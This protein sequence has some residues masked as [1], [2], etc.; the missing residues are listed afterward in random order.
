[1][2][3]KEYLIKKLLKS[4]AKTAEGLAKAKRKAAKKYRTFCPANY[5]LLKAYH[6]L[7]KNKRI[8][9]K[10]AIENLL[11]SRPV[12]S[13]SGIVNISL[14][15]KPYPCPGKCIYCPSQKGAPKSYLKNEP[16]VMRAILNKYSPLKQVRMRLKALKEEGH[17]TDKIEMRIIGGTWSYYPE[18]YQ[19]WF[20]KKC[21]Q[22]CN[23][24]SGEKSFEKTLKENETAKH[25]IVGL[26]VETRPDFITQK[27]IKRMR[28]LGITAVELGV[29]SL[30]DDVLETNKR[31]HGVEKTVLAT[32]LLKDAGF[33]VCYQMMPNLPGSTLK[34]D[35]EMFQ[36]L[37]SDQRFRPDWLKIY[38]TA[39][40]KGSALHKLW[41]EKKYKPYSDRQMINLVKEIK[42]IVPYYL[43][44]QRIVRDIP[45]NSIE[46]GPARLSNLRQI[47]E[48]EAL[49]EGWKCKCIRCREI[50]NDYDPKE[51]LFLFRQNYKASE[52]KEIFLSY[53]SKNRR[54]LY[55]LLRM[56]IPR[57]KNFPKNF[58]PVLE[59][60]A[61]VREIH[62]YGRLH[63]LNYTGCTRVISPQHRGMGKKLLKEAEK[64]AKKEF[65]FSKIAVISGIGVR[66][67]YRKLRYRL[68]NT[69]MVKTL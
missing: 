6:E 44:I 59:N 36:L 25:R 42:K 15:T 63:P 33:K 46:E 3:I 69:Y 61:L 40:L 22:A 67:Y 11:I 19:S 51:K 35:K 17:P 38:P 64:I 13:L 28:E 16:A 27:E 30:F 4:G 14:L 65:G 18:K 20:I 1:M 56:R 48:K 41:K 32:R 21:F 50:R 43:R 53:E 66:P 39:V 23:G 68:K 62:T 52:G 34:K 58:F 60:S 29:Q 10:E 2:E 5:E 54:R 8:K 7:L 9:R 45:S 47:V 49:K 37:F 55:S 31:G 24:S 57:K 12:R 26:S